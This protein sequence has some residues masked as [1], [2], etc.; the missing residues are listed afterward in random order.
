[1]TVAEY[2]KVMRYKQRELAERAGLS[3]AMVCQ[4]A[5]GK[6]RPSKTTAMRLAKA[7]DGLITYPVDSLRPYRAARKRQ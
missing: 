1:M 5:S 7:S 3:S 2:L 4:I 6:R